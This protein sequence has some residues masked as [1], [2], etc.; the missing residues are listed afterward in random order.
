MRS[1]FIALTGQWGRDIL[2]ILSRR[3][4]SFQKAAGTPAESL[5]ARSPRAGVHEKFANALGPWIR[6]GRCLLLEN[7]IVRQK[8]VNHRSREVR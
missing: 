1:T 3:A 6:L 8:S 5:E 7:W 2:M 4:D